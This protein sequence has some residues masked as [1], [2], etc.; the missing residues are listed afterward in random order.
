MKNIALKNSLRLFSII[1]FLV[2][3]SCNH[4]EGSANANFQSTNVTPTLI[5]NGEM[6]GNEAGTIPQQNIVITNTTDWD[7]LKNQM[8]IT[9]GLNENGIDFSTCVVIASFDQVRGNGGY[10]INNLDIVE[11]SNNIIISVQRTGPPGPFATTVMTQ[12]F[13][14][15]RIPISP[16]PIIFN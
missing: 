1:I 12:P 3:T 16:K 6:Y 15:V 8:N 10:Q 5:G 13:S 14:I 4:D 7:N 11:N 2:L 9:S